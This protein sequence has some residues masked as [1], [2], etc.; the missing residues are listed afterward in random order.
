VDDVTKRAYIDA[1]L[2]RVADDLATARHNLTHDHWRGAVNR[3]YYAVFHTASAALLWLNI[4]RAKHSGVQAAFGEFLVKPGTIESEF[5]QIYTKI[6]KAR[7]TEDYDVMAVL[8]TAEAAS[9]IVAEAERFVT[10]LE[11]YLR[12]VGRNNQ[13][14][15]L[16]LSYSLEY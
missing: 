11:S 7:E 15:A 5:G 2:A 3:V 12:Q 8:L 6:R 10:R 13:V 14:P 16:I 1:H 4:E 9:Q